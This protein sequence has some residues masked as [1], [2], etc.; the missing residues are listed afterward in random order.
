MKNLSTA[1]T[2]EHEAWPRSFDIRAEYSEQQELLTAE[3][4]PMVD[5]APQRDIPLQGKDK[6]D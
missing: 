1:N 5:V 3:F 6:N 4:S 2:Q